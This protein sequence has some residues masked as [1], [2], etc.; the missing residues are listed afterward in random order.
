MLEMDTEYEGNVEAT[1]EDF[2]AKPVESRRLFMLSLMLVLSERLL[3]TMFLV[4]ARELWMAELIFL[5]VTRGLLDL[6]RTISNLI[7]KFTQ[8]HLR[9]PCCCNT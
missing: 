8:I 3:V 7:L 6:T 4:F 1:G 2:T 5:T 9:W